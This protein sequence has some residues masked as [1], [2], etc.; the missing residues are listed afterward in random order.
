VKIS[1]VGRGNVGGGLAD[2]WEK[3]DHDVARL[4]KEGGDVSDADAV[5]VAVPGG[6]LAEALDKVTGLDGDCGS[7][8]ELIAN[9]WWLIVFGSAAPSH[10]RR[11]SITVSEGCVR[12]LPW[13]SQ[14]CEQRTSS[15]TRPGCSQGR[16]SAR[17][18]RALASVDSHSRV[19]LEGS[20]RLRHG[21]LGD[22]YHADPTSLPGCLDRLLR[23]GSVRDYAP[24]T[25]QRL[26]SVPAATVAEVMLQSFH[27]ASMTPAI[28]VTV[29]RPVATS[30]DIG[31]K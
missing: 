3:A 11:A 1:V 26:V 17:D 24:R 13:M 2:L 12:P 7:W 25:A 15:L 27:R 22:N 20:R 4:G 6:D 23:S 8:S 14:R 29:V 19:V 10:K 31:G 18:Y 28:P 5:L 9:H 16:A 30:P 21:R